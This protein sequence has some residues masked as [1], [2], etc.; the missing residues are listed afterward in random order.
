MEAGRIALRT[1]PA[2]VPDAL[3]CTT[4]APE[5]TGRAGPPCDAEQ[6]FAALRARIQAKEAAAKR[7]REA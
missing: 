7:L 1:S 2:Q 6:R 4:P 5:P 3:V